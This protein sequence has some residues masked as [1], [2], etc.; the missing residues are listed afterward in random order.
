MRLKDL[1]F[2]IGIDLFGLELLTSS[3]HYGL[4]DLSKVKIIRTYQERAINTPVATVRAA[5]ASVSR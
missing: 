5:K 4:N 3:S 2:P 1:V